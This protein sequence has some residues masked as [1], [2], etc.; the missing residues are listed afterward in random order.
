MRFP[1]EWSQ[2]H[3]TLAH[4]LPLW[5]PAQCRGLA[6]W[7]CGT[8]LAQSRCQNAVMTALLARGAWHGLRQRWREW[9]YDGPDNAAP[10]RAQLDVT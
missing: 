6:L 9:R 7:V 10:C 2:M 5:R 4:S 8:I 1:S 3:V